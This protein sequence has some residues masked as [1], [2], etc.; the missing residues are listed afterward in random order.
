MP[1]AE[2]EWCPGSNKRVRTDAGGEDP[3]VAAQCLDPS[4]PICSCFSFILDSDS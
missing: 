1:V 4:E 3:L 2:E